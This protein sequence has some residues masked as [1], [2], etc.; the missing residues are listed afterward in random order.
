[1]L[2]ISLTREQYERLLPLKNALQRYYYDGASPGTLPTVETIWE[3]ISGKQK[4]CCTG[5]S[6]YRTMYILI[7]DYEKSNT[8]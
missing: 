2:P 1:M 8:K 6:Y 4:G 7:E 3:E 5:K